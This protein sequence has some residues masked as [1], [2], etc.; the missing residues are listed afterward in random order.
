MAENILS[1]LMG[2]GE[3]ERKEITYEQYREVLTAQVEY[4]KE[5][6]KEINERIYACNPSEV[7]VYAIYA[8][9]V[10]KEMT[11]MANEVTQ[12]G[13]VKDKCKFYIAEDAVFF[14]QYSPVELAIEEV[15]KKEGPNHSRDM[16]I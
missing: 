6:Y 3:G 8:G 12:A 4:H 7:M 10:L 14:E 5:Q 11:E 2:V 9:N 13:L 16:V 1:K 15:F